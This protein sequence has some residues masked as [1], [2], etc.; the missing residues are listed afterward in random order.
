[1]CVCVCVCVKEFF[2][3]AEEIHT[4]D[5]IMFEI[6]YNLTRCFKVLDIENRDELNYEVQLNVLP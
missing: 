5:I 2:L 1:V 3:E 4:Q 6:F